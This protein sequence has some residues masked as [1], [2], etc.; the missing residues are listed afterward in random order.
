M[1]ATVQIRQHFEEIIS[2]KQAAIYV[3]SVSIA[4]SG[5]CICSALL[6]D[7]QLLSFGNFCFSASSQHFSSDLL[8]R[9][10]R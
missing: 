3:I 10:C 4:S 7:V 8:I 2:V 6:T 9:F 5:V 1:D